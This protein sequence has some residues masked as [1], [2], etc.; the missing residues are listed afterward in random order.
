[1]VSYTIAQIESLITKS[2]LN[3]KFIILAPVV[4]TRKGH[5]RDLFDQIFKQGFI[6]VRVDGEIQNITPGLKLDRYKSHDIEIVIDRIELNDKNKKRLKDSINIALKYGKGVLQIL[7]PIDN[8]IRFFSRNLMCPSTGISYD[9]PEPNSFSFNS[10]KGA[11]ETCNG[12]GLEMNIDLTKI[13]PDKNLSIEQGGIA[14]IADR[15]SKWIE[16]QLKII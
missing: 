14:P 6:K 4:K 8:S 12:L 16:K 2:Y 9:N 7:D 15:N 3:Q 5:Y 1:M 11:C 10:P 13:F